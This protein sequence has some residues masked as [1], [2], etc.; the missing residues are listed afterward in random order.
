MRKKERGVER[1]RGGV[2]GREEKDR[3]DG[4]RG[5]RRGYL[6]RMDCGVW[7]LDCF[8]ILG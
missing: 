4:R 6:A 2:G 8:F 1:G 3:R 5:K 7:W